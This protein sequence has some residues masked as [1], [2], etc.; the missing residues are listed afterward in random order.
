MIGSKLGPYELIE[1]VGRGG[2]AAVYRA[3]QPNVDRFVA[4]KVIYRSIAA[5][6]K[7]LE[8][9][10]REARLVAK[11]EHP[12]ILPVYDY[13]G[14]NDPPYIVMRYLPTGT[15]KDVL[16]RERLPVHEVAYLFGQIASALD[17]AHRQGIVHRDI[18]PSNIMVDAEGNAFL[19]D[20]GIAR[21]VEAS[22]G[23]GLTGTG[24]AIGTP[25][26]MAPEQGLGMAIDGR[27]DIYSLGVMLFELL[28]GVMPF[29]AETP[30]AMIL[31]HISDPLPTITAVN[32]NLP[33]AVNDVILKSLAKKPEDRYATSTDMARALTV[34]LGPSQESS[35]VRLQAV[36]ARTI[37]DLAAVRAEKAKKL[38][39]QTMS[40]ATL[41]PGS[42]PSPSIPSQASRPAVPAP[43]PGTGGTQPT[44]TVSTVRGA[45]LGAGAVIMLIALIGL[46]ALIATTVITSASNNNATA[47]SAAVALTVGANNTLVA[48]NS[49]AAQVAANS[50]ATQAADA[51]AS[52]TAIAKG[53]QTAT[54][55]TAIAVAATDDHKTKVVTPTETLTPS[56]Q[57]S[58]TAAEPATDIT[59][60]AHP[61]GSPAPTEKASRTPKPSQTPSVTNTPTNTYTFTPSATNTPVPTLRPQPT[62]TPYPT[63]TP[64]PSNTPTPTPS[65]TL[66]PALPT[67]TPTTVTAPT[68]PPI[69][70]PTTAPTL[71]PI[72]PATV[73]PVV[74]PTAQP[75]GQLPYVNDMEAPDAIKQWD[76]DPTAWKLSP[77]SGNTAL[78]GSGGLN[79]PAVVLGKSNP[80]AEWTDPSN[81]NLYLTISIDL[82]SPQSVG[83]VIF[84]LSNSGYYVIELSSGTLKLSRGTAAGKI[85]RPSERTMR[86]GQISAPFHSGSFYKW[87][88]WADDSRIFIYLEDRLIMQVRDGDTPLPGGQIMFQTLSP[89]PSYSV[90]FDNI[91]VQRPAP[92][93]QHFEGASFPATWTRSNLT[94]AGIGDDGNGNHYIE[95]TN[96]T[97]SP[98]T[99]ALTDFLVACRISSVQGGFD[100]RM[101][102][103]SS[104]YFL[105]HF[106]S[107]NMTLSTVDNAGKAT[108]VQDFPN[109]YAHGFFQD[110]TFEFVGDRLT[111]YT[112]KDL[113]SQVI[114]N[115]PASGTM[116]F[117]I[118]R[119]D[120]SV[121]LDDFLIAE[122]AK[123]ATEIAQWAFDKIAAV[124][125]RADRE[126]YTEFY[127]RFIDKLAKRDW[128]E[129]GA[130]APGEPKYD[131]KSRDYSNYLQMTYQD[132]ASYRIF[133][134]VPGAKGFLLFGL[135]NDKQ[136]FHDSSDIYVRV[137]VRLSQAGTAWVAAR[138]SKSVG[139]GALDGYKLAITRDTDGKFS[140]TA[141]VI[142]NTGQETDYQK[143][144]MPVT[145]DN[146]NPTWVPLLIIAWQDRVAFF[147]NGKFVS[148]QEKIDILGGTVALGV[149]KDS[150]ADFNFFQ[151]RDVSPDKH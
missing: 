38:A 26:Y 16:E 7:A 93:S 96:G 17:Y 9:F 59:E 122:T 72:V 97:V 13:N 54:A 100:L 132:G 150:V 120:D 12:H 88:I 52:D 75:P 58:S 92:A 71:P 79:K 53:G 67:I 61:S 147:V 130:N 30:M 43:T 62:Y 51:R 144:P 28:A 87:T 23:P 82:D 117:L 140:V 121:R 95:Q 102:E 50:T 57:V 8:R 42:T 78:V 10:Q 65:I 124:E 84:R 131:G 47:T 6:A 148:S 56:P 41:P 115:A 21:I 128:W 74:L 76:L 69:L 4:V 2:M 85:D 110:F 133:R 45:A 66:T 70:P 15:L 55:A 134:Y 145:A 114:K 127:D 11:L 3:Y 37:D 33:P 40:G 81:R 39:D 63:F 5:D 129:G 143:V 136:T 141:A 105:F 86:G 101:R 108:V 31:K 113:W 112:T 32:P 107:G 24:M 35:P 73:P 34:A 146:P 64:P 151:L 106:E 27:A 119:K 18:K 126:L 138:T 149:D 116:S 29:Q 89:S 48:A 44:T 83:R 125:A 60:T 94:D 142:S 90:R 77:D 68:L 98:N 14:L 99:G 20:F 103:S 19:T 80:A 123:S 111:I 109:F 104:G 36:A 1:E 91:K 46:G 118:A 49:T 137:N 139:G 22:T 25:D 135:G